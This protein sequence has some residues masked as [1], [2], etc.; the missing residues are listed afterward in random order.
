MKE[1]EYSLVYIELDDLALLRDFAL[2]FL[3]TYHYCV[4][5]SNSLLAITLCQGAA[6]HYA[7]CKVLA[8]RY[9]DPRKK[10]IKDFDV[11][12]FFRKEYERTFNPRWYQQRDLGKTKFGSNPNEP[13]F[14]GRRVDFFWPFNRVG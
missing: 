6:N 12:F 14:Q 9:F 7:I 5:F 11:W 8:R 1:Q 2:K 3:K 4:K 13:V 10:G